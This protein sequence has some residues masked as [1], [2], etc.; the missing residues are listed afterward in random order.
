MS[1]NVRKLFTN[2]LSDTARGLFAAF[3]G[4]SH[5]GAR[6][7][8][9]QFGYKR[10]LNPLDFYAMYRR[11]DIANRIVRGYPQATWR[12]TPVVRD[13]AADN[14][15]TS[16]FVE[17]F[18]NLN[19]AFRLQWYFERADRL[20][21]LG[22]YSVLLMGFDGNED[23]AYPL[24]GQHKL[25]YLSPYSEHNTIVNQWDLDTRSPRFGMP[26][27]YTLQK[28]NPVTGGRTVSQT[29]SIT[30]HWSRV[31]HLAETLDD[32]DVFGIPRLECVFN[33]LMD[34][35]KVVG[36]GAETFWLNS[37][38]G[39]MLTADKDANISPAGIADL[40]DQAESF[41][42]QL[43]RTMAMQGVTAQVLNAA[44]ADPSNHVS[45][46]LDLIAG[47][48]GY[49]KRILIGSERG[50]LSSSQDENNWS[51]RID[52]R[53]IH[54]ATPNIIKPFIYSMIETGNMPEPSGEWW[55]EW[56][57]VAAQS[58]KEKAEI[59]NLKATAVMNYL[60]SPGAE[61]VVP[62]E[63]FRVWIGEEPVSEF[64]PTVLDLPPVN[65][66]NPQVKDQFSK[67][68][69]IRIRNNKRYIVVR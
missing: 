28:G 43:R 39:M 37:R 7:L 50:E 32:D 17:A 40:K 10:I 56:P 49:P 58:P 8:Y 9:K 44:I 69:E 64:E 60:R 48:T 35:E 26:K 62:Q 2:S 54:F 34:L 46:L 6:N 52:E 27:L 18:E 11:N 65:E 22:R 16:A 67:N 15:D 30:V 31:I 51:A 25:L 5:D 14:S 1:N 21:G 63:E 42:H 68:R 33:R 29:R 45:T 41:E 3:L 4:Y 23:M 38:Q 59:A 47:A 66:N 53:R 20:S 24:Q 57:E 55:T 61:L 13:D 36:G 12:D 19:E